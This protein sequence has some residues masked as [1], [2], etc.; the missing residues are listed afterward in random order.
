MRSLLTLAVGGLLLTASAASAQA[1][2]APVGPRPS[3]NMQRPG[4]DIGPF[5]GGAKTHRAA[6]GR[7]AAHAKTHRADH[8]R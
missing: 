8:P 3:Y 7:A 1:A 6:A 5:A 4:E 2:E